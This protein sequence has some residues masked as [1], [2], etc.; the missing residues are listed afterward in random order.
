MNGAGGGEGVRSDYGMAGGCVTDVV[1]HSF[2]IYHQ[3]HATEPRR[4]LKD[5]VTA[6]GAVIMS[7]HRVS[8]LYK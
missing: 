4:R 5:V 8:H 1:L 2:E 7:F 6:W 3:E